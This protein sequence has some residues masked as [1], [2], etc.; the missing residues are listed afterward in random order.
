MIQNASAPPIELSIDQWAI[1]KDILKKYVPDIQV[2]AFGSRAKWAAKPY[3]DLDLTL[4]SA[5][6]LEVK[7]LGQLKY[8]FEESKLPFN[9]DLLEWRTAPESF[10]KMILPDLL[11]LF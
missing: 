7:Q 5:D 3:S 10:K 2:C 8:A 1:V 6:P 11:A 9:V 4:I